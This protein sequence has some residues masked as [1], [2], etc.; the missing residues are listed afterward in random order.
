[1]IN[2]YL[3]WV[4][5]RILFLF[6]VFFLLFA[7]ACVSHLKEAKFYYVQGQKYSR[8]YQE[9]KAVSAFKKAL[10]EAEFEAEINPSAQA[11]MLKGM[12]EAEL[13]LWDKAEQSFLEAFSYGFERGEEWAEE[14]SLL[15]LAQSFQE[16]GIED[17]AFKIYSHL[18]QKSKLKQILLVASQRYTDILLKRAKQ[19]K[20]KE[21][22]RLLTQALKSAQKLAEKDLSCGFFHYLLSQIYSH[23]F[24]YKESFEEAVMARELGLPSRKILGDNDLQI[25][26]CY[27]KLKEKLSSEEWEKFYSLYLKW[28][29]KWN[30]QGPQTPAWKKR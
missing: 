26:F 30:W 12:T 13:E 9:E 27:Q 29:K 3:M 24:S 1:M 21:K 10:K 14:L 4:R 19:K 16:L 7:S 23:L 15:G 11:L 25:V 28:V 2:R 20:D 5:K 17:S 18:M 22:E 6:V 8:S